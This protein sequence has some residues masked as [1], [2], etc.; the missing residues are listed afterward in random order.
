MYGRGYLVPN[1]LF[2]V[3]NHTRTPRL[4]VATWRLQEKM[5]TFSHTMLLY[6]V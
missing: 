1:D 4:D 6:S 2:F 3:R 5:L